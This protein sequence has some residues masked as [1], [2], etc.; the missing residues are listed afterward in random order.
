MKYKANVPVESKS[1]RTSAKAN[2]RAS[3]RREGDVWKF[4]TANTAASPYLHVFFSSQYCNLCALQRAVCRLLQVEITTKLVLP[5]RYVFFALQCL[6]RSL[7]SQVQNRWTTL[8]STPVCCIF[9]K[10]MIFIYPQLCVLP[11]SH[12]PYWKWYQ[13]IPLYTIYRHIA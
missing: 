13:T 12:N 11:S 1:L 5:A 7:L 2:E 10:N 4:A 8:H 9:K 6:E 3:R